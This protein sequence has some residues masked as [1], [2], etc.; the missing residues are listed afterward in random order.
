ME[1]PEIVVIPIHCLRTIFNSS[2]DIVLRSNWL[3]FSR[4][5]AGPSRWSVH[6]VCLHVCWRLFSA[7]VDTDRQQV[8]RCIK[9][10]GVGG[11]KGSEISGE[12]PRRVLRA[13]REHRRSSLGIDGH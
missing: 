7:E 11:V 1:E 6:R 10:S 13:G 3:D 8:R 4:E 12:T 2:P 9:L 5:A